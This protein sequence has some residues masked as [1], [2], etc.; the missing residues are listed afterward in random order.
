ML[1]ASKPFPP[2]ASFRDFAFSL[3]SFFSTYFLLHSSAAWRAFQLEIRREIMAKSTHRQILL[4]LENKWR[5][6][7]EIGLE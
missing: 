7:D 4:L 3:L 2:R 1:S 6:R 5:Q